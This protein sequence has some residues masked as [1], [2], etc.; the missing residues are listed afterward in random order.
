MG[1]LCPLFR[2]LFLLD[3][4]HASVSS[5]SFE[6]HDRIGSGMTSGSTLAD[7]YSPTYRHVR[8]I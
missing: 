3:R 5:S 8:I 1:T 2:G 7:G 4:I 6:A